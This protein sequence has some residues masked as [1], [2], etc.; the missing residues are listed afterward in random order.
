MEYRFSLTP[1]LIALAIFSGVALLVL[2]FALGYEVGKSMAERPAIIDR[3][4]QQVMG[5]I[6]NDAAAAAAPVTERVK[7]VQKAAQ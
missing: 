6:S 1:R 3:K 7:A 2:L 5:K 4:S